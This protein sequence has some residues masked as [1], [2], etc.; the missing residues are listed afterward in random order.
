MVVE[1]ATREKDDLL[2]ALG[3]G[4]LGQFLGRRV[5][6]LVLANGKLKNFTQMRTS[7]GYVI[8]HLVE[9]D[10]PVSRTGS[11]L[12]RR[13]G[14]SQ[15]AASKAIAELVRLGA[16]EVT[17]S[18]DRRAKQVSLSASGWAAVQQTRRYRALLEDRLRQ[19]VGT[20]Q[21]AKA[22]KILRDCLI[23]LG[24]ADRIRSRRI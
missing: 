16:V 4:Y 11:D 12:A 18:S 20:K 21:Y 14:V 17:G 1:Q 15:Q 6:E 8:Q 3:L 13:M 19:S 7:H 10:H 24:G 9:T 2:M 22:Q 5:N 23:L